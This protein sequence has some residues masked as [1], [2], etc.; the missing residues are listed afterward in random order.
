MA[1]QFTTSPIHEEAQSSPFI[2]GSKKPYTS[3]TPINF[4][5]AFPFA[6]AL[7]STSS[8][9]PELELDAKGVKSD[10]IKKPDV[11]GAKNRRITKLR[12]QITSSKK[13]LESARQE[14]DELRAKIEDLKISIA[15]AEKNLEQ[16]HDLKY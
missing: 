3:D 10:A 7:K 15:L 13:L 4:D 12:Q 2:F 6:R 9:K 11:N 8:P 14:R 5:E 16:I 1:F